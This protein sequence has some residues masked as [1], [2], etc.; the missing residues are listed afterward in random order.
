MIVKIDQSRASVCKQNSLTS[1]MH[2]V[3]M[4][5]GNSPLVQPPGFDGRYVVH[6]LEFVPPSKQY[7]E[8]M[9]FIFHV[10]RSGMNLKLFVCVVRGVLF[11]CTAPL[12]LPGKNPPNWFYNPLRLFFSNSIP[13]WPKGVWCAGAFPARSIRSAGWG[14]NEVGVPMVGISLCFSTVDLAGFGVNMEPLCWIQQR[15]W[16]KHI[17][18]IWRIILRTNVY[19]LTNAV[20]W[21]GHDFSSRSL[22][23][24]TKQRLKVWKSPQKWPILTPSGRLVTI[25]LTGHDSRFSSFEDVDGVGAMW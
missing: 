11:F 18:R 19:G 16:T 5:D 23:L 22:G 24:T 25:D 8:H 21:L 14:P 15:N 2:W 6:A 4:G 9:L 13:W 10:L 12:T 7:L 17:V 20:C 1:S 3:N